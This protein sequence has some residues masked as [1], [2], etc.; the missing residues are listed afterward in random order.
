MDVYRRSLP[1]GHAMSLSWY[2][3]SSP[4]TTEKRVNPIY[5]YIIYTY[6]YE[7]IHIYTY[8]YI[9]IWIYI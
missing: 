8:L 4:D 3:L 2:W 9:Y 1:R 6:E 7:H 5:I